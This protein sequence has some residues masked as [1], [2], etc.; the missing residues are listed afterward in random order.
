MIKDNINLTIKSLINEKHLKL[1]LIDSEE[2]HL[3]IYFT[4]YCYKLE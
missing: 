1:S 3:N 2:E 4:W